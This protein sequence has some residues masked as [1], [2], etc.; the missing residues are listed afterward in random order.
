MS[1][2]TAEKL[3][4]DAPDTPD[5]PGLGGCRLQYCKGK[6]CDSDRNR[7]SF[8]HPEVFPCYCSFFEDGFDIGLVFF[9]LYSPFSFCSVR[10]RFDRNLNCWPRRGNACLQL[11]TALLETPPSFHDNCEAEGNRYRSR[12][13]NR[14]ALD[15]NLTGRQ[16]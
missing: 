8:P 2:P 12:W 3:G 14:W 6:T 10:R 13:D 16:M 1:S 7:C 15:E 11:L 5:L 4:I 9:H